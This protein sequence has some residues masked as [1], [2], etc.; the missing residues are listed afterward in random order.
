MV[1]NLKDNQASFRIV[2]YIEMANQSR[3]TIK[4]PVDLFFPIISSFL[5]GDTNDE[6]VHRILSLYQV[7]DILF[8]IKKQVQTF[9]KFFSGLVS[10]YLI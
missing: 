9:S 8:L 3:H 7:V 5:I 1:R 6:N 4:S 10:A 2:Y